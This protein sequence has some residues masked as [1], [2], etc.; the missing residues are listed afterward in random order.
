[1]DF[2]VRF[3]NKDSLLQFRPDFATGEVNRLKIDAKQPG[4]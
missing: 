3:I 2:A 1:M 4:S